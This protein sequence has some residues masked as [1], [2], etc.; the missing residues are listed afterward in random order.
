MFR[1]PRRL[2]GTTISIGRGGGRGLF[3]HVLSSF[4]SW[5]VVLRLGWGFE[6]ARVI[7]KYK[8]V[9]WVSPN[10]GFPPTMGVY[11]FV[12]RS[13]NALVAPVCHLHPFLSLLLEKVFSFRMHELR[14][15]LA[16]RSDE[17]R[18]RGDLCRQ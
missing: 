17:H 1:L 7:H 13:L 3:R 9:G 4:L 11:D 6:G 15:T 5:G 18:Q 2:Q 14:L 8:C 10:N 12:Q 16:L